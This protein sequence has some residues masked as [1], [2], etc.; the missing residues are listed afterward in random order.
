MKL[1]F[2]DQLA[3]PAE[4]LGETARA[5]AFLSRLPVPLR[6][7]SGA[8]SPLSEAVR[9]FPLAG[10]VIALPAAVLLALLSA[11]NAPYFV[12]GGLVVALQIAV[13]GALHEDGLADTLDG[14]GAGRD[15]ERA[16]AIMK[17]SRIGT[18]GTI[19]LVLSI[20]LRAAGIGVLA[21]V[22]SPLAAMFAFLG[23]AAA[24]R[25]AMVWHWQALPSARPD[26]VAGK[27]GQPEETPASWAI[28]LGVG[29]L[30][31][32]LVPS[33]GVVAGAV[34]ACGHCRG[35]GPLH[36]PDRQPPRRTNRRHDRRRP[37]TGRACRP[38]R[39]GPGPLKP[40]KPD[41]SLLPFRTASTAMTAI[42]S[43]CILVCSIDMKTGYCFGCGRTREEIAAWMTMSGEARRDVMREL[44]ARLATVER[45]PRRETRRDANGPRKAGEMR[46]MRRRY[47]FP[48]VM[49]VLGGA[50]VLLLFNR[51][52]GLVFGIPD[53]TFA[54]AA[55]LT[56]WAAVLAAGVLS[57][58]RIREIAR[59]M[60]IW[61]VALLALSTLYVY[62]YDLQEAG[63]R[64]TAGLIP[65]LPIT[66][67]GLNGA[68]EVILQKTKSGHFEATAWV[69]G[70]RVNFLIDTGASTVVLTYRD[71]GNIGLDPAKLS[72]T[73]TVQTANGNA[74]AAFVNLDSIALG[75]IERDNVRASVSAPGMLDQSLLGM[76]FLE[77]LTSFQMSRDMLVLQD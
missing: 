67:T 70:H 54:S 4:L 18:F 15:P 49:G 64:L 30:V 72:F 29:I 56:A 55:A 53:D 47:V 28:A 13:T 63:A 23:I 42:E 7:F 44:P 33:C 57:S 16:L 38:R 10:L 6:F 39:A 9:S 5:V 48:L 46:P 75:P 58:G 21:A 65:G 40:W 62:R 2:K 20:G 50:L 31:V 26:G 41:V 71:A 1:E 19:G 25:A 14:L 12:A 32:C 60:T 17:D 8:S 51:R 11:A 59:N 24:S 77:T 52:N 76:D 22:L 36:A 61:V 69:D 68:T 35:D 66:R 27:A 45:K 73:Q 74:K 34:R 37:A 43:P 3:L